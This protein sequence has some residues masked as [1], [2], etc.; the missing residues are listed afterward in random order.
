MM[1]RIR[2]ILGRAGTGKTTRCVDAAADALRAGGDAPL[3]L[4]TPEQATY[5]MELAVLSRPGVRGFSRLR[6]LS[7]NRL[8]FWLSRRLGAGAELSRLGRQMAVH[9]AILE[10]ADEL[11]LYRDAARHTGLAARMSGLLTELQEADCGAEQVAALAQQVARHQAGGAAARK[12]ADIEKIFAAY[13]AFFEQNTELSNPDALLTQARGEIAKAGFLQGAQIWVDGFSGFTVQERQLVVE[14]ARHAERMEIALCLDA[15]RIDL[16]STDVETLDPAGLFF[17]TEQ[18]YAELLGVFGKC[19]FTIEPPVILGAAHRYAAAPGLGHLEAQLAAETVAGDAKADGAV[20]VV[21]CADARAEAEWIAGR[22]CEW[23]RQ[24][25]VR[26]RQVGVAVPD[27]EGYGPYIEPAFARYGIPYFLDRPAGV[28]H[29]PV[30]ET[31]QAALAAA[32]GFGTLDVLCCLKSGLMGV[33]AEAVSRLEQYCLRYGVDGDDWTSETAWGFAEDAAQNAAM[34]A[35]RRRIVGPL[36][37][38]QAAVFGGE[39]IEAAAF[40][41]GVWGFLERI[42]ARQTLAAWAAQDA[43]D[44]RGHRQTWA[45]VAAVL[46]EMVR[47]FGPRRERAGVFVSTLADALGSLTIKLIPPTLDQVLVGSIER[48][49][50]P[51]IRAIFLAGATQKQFPTPLSTT[52]VLGRREREAARAAGLELAEPMTQQLSKRQY[53]AYIAMTRASEYVGISF[54][55]QD[56]KGAATAPSVWVERVESV[57][58]DVRRRAV[59][60]GQGVW[61]SGCVQQLAERLAA[62]CGKDRTPGAQTDA[63]AYVL[64]AAGRSSSSA[65]RAAAARVMDGLGYTNAAEIAGNE[66][67]SRLGRVERFSASR[68]GMFAAC[69]Y[70]HFARYGLGL[71]RRPILR[72]EPL[73]VGL[74]YHKVVEVLFGRLR[75]RGLSWGTA[76]AEALAAL[77]EAVIAERMESDATIAAYLR[78]QRHHRAIVEAACEG[79]RRFVPALAELERAGVFR[80]AG[81]E[82]DFSFELG[83]GVVLYG[84]IDRVDTAEVGGKKAAA[85]FDFKR[86]DRSVNWTKVYHGLDVQLVIYLLAIPSL[87]KELEA[88]VVAGAFYVPIEAAGTTV[89]PDAVEAKRETFAYKAKGVFDGDFAAALDGTA[90]GRSGYYNFAYDKEGQPYSYYGNSGALRPEDFET[91]LAY[92]RRKIGELAAGVKSGLIAAEPYRIGK[93]SPCGYCDYQSVCRFDWQINDYRVLT[94]VNKGEAIEKMREEL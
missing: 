88:E 52:D 76:D 85:I 28:R 26:Y 23:V 50:H 41:R 17:T 90:C 53:L 44:T 49:R 31:L 72:F 6:V 73:D 66:A 7:F 40:V 81:S 93:T 8:G 92:G 36:A 13:T 30:A 63:A 59:G 27:M 87:P 86:T 67:L 84:R 70:Q 14:M 89:S 1:G 32:D 16:A 33:A 74:F 54:P 19:S 94:A 80:Q 75:E 91:L 69:P 20:E 46:D 79:V 4:L 56:E 61:T 43:A 51:E 38:M 2:F 68:L 21:C 37:E 82:V 18:T 34:E 11:T 29:H 83:R 71:E 64:D 22:I 10:T 35:L 78:R 5:Q 57:F 48:S 3:V 47:V 55:Q 15:G 65:I 12:W 77:C 9:R 45:Q 58:A 24:G 25:G 42:G 60:S 39:A 62:A